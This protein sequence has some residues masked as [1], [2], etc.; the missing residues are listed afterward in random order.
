MSKY[1]SIIRYP[2][3]TEKN[4]NLRALQNKYVFEVAKDA[5]KKDIKEAVENIFDVT[6]ETVNTIVV[7]GKK[8]RMGRY[9]G[10]RP[11]WKKAFVKLKEGQS[12][13]QFGEV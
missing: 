4:T 10:H 12:I 7:K 8:K 5:S 9:S 1:H 3:I 2:S 13:A 6:V 11:D